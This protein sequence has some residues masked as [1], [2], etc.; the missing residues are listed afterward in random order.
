MNHIQ[1]PD[2]SFDEAE[3]RYLWR[4]QIVI[5][6]TS[7]FDR[8]GYRKSSNDFWNPLGIP[9]FCKSEESSGWGSA[10]HKI[11]EIILNGG[12][13]NIPDPEKAEEA[14]PY[15][16]GFNNFLS[17]YPTEPLCDQ[18]G[19]KIIEYPLYSELLKL[20]GTPDFF[21]LLK[22]CFVLLDWKTSEA[23]AKTYGPQTAAYEKL[24]KEV[25]ENRPL[26][27]LEGEPVFIRP[28]SKVKRIT[29]LFGPKF[30]KGYKPCE[31]KGSDWN[32]FLSILN[33]YKFAER[34]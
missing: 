31:G 16:E 6:V 33:T 2:L 23:Y 8:V 21:G 30:K 13:V 26:F 4:G 24:V 18:N 22:S 7:V 10:F 27:T 11:P 32:D 19:K 3:H 12:S 15:I 25:F 9:D 5:G 20:A 14:K 29:V 34:T 17:D 28:S 1:Y